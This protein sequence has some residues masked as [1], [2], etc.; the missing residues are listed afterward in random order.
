MH[1]FLFRLLTAYSEGDGKGKKRP[2]TVL[3]SPLPASS[4]DRS[5]DG[6]GAHAGQQRPVEARHTPA[7]FL[8]QEKH[9]GCTVGGDS[10]R[11]FLSLL[12]FLTQ[13]FLDFEAP[14]SYLFC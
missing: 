2:A 7:D 12:I 6:R 13:F 1:L 4:G 3:A 8:Q 11:Y 14:F 5:A 9:D 10:V